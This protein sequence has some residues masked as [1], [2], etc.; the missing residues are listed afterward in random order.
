MLISV[1]VKTGKEESKLEKLQDGTYSANL[2]SLPTK[3]RANKELIKL[4]ATYFEVSTREVKIKSGQYSK[5][6]VIF[7]SDQNDLGI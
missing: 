3:N 2:K 4:V 6:K 7:I 1:L 5:N